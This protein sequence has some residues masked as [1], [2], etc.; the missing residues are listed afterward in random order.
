MEVV[1][2]LRRQMTSDIAV[3]LPQPRWE[4]RG[5]ANPVE[6]AQKPEQRQVESESESEEAVDCC[7]RRHW[8]AAPA[9]RP[10]A[11]QV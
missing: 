7:R 4:D 6:Q 5:V 10:A 2:V 9:A 11:R 3:V 1:V 8:Q